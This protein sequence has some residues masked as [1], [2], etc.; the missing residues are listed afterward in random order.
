MFNQDYFR[1]K[2]MWKNNQLYKCMCRTWWCSF[3]HSG[4]YK[5]MIYFEILLRY[6]RASN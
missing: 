3:E 6:L 5:M 4:I 1:F 2:Y